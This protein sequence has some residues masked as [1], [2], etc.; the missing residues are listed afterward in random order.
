MTDTRRASPRLQ[1]LGRVSPVVWLGVLVTLVA[2][3]AAVFAPSLA[4]HDPLSSS[5]AIRLQGPSAENYLGTDGFG[6]DV[7]S[8]VLYGARVSLGVGVAVVVL[9]TIFGTVTG[10]VAGYYRRL[11]GPIM[12]VMDGLMAFPAILLAI[13]IMGALGPGVQNVVLALSIVYW[14]RTARIV[15]GSVLSIR[16]LDYV[17][18]ARSLGASDT[19]I[20]VRH[21]LPGAA[22]PVFVQA[23]FVLAATILAEAGLSFIGAG[24]PAPHPSWG[25]ILAEG[26]LFMRNAP[27]MTVF[28]GLAITVV[29]LSLNLVGD[30]LIDYLD[31]K[32]RRQTA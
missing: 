3:A 18:G 8:R 27:W 29:V 6:R 9:S 12:R 20:I 7:Y 24:V 16:E 14:P 30:G 19:R 10:L 17:D 22:S 5:V 21:I 11:D 13:A 4:T 28:P 2:V 1:L 31:P 26:R 32:R 25:S 15:R 23:T